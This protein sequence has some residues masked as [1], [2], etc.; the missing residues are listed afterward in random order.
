[1]S[2]TPI[3]LNSRIRQMLQLLRPFAVLDHR[4][5][6]VGSP[7]DGGYIMIDDF[8]AAK[9]AYSFGIGEDVNW[10]IQIANRGLM[11]YQ[12]DHTVNEPPIQ[13]PSFHFHK[14]GLAPEDGGEFTS[15]VTALQTNGHPAR[16]DL[17]LKIDVEG[18]EWSTFDQLP[19]HVLSQFRQIIIE[20]HGFLR[21]SERDWSAVFMRVLQ[22]I[23]RSHAVHHVHANNWGRY[24]I[25]ANVPVPDVL[26]VSYI[27][28][29]IFRLASSTEIY[30]TPIDA[31][32]DPSQP[33][34][35]LGSFVF[36]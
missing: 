23:H 1:M 3:E 4:Q 25:V 10:D 6:R 5:V 18:A 19:D 32:C 13:H 30:P 20:Y 31:P 36:D 24:Q 28:R 7:A 15:I 2:S 8:A 34:I 12:Y 29:D 9:V 16:N 33:E 26:E 27:R 21:V 17:I 35:H 14:L 11:V 22:K